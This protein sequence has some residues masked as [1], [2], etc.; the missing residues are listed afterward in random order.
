MENQNIQQKGKTNG[1]AITSLVVGILAW[2][3]AI[4]LACLNWVILPLVTVATM[5]FGGLLYI[6]TLAVG[7]LSPL[8]WLIGVITGYTA[9]NQIKQT[10]M[11]GAG[12][13]N[14]GFII[15]LIGLG[16]TILGICGIVIYAIAVG[17]F[18][19]LD[20]LQY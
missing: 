8:G 10:G 11:D 18:G 19:F 14:A 20:Q 7:C 13:A 3:L 5:G 16:L 15:N 17:G 1:L 2:V 6:C 4:A 9:K 12:M